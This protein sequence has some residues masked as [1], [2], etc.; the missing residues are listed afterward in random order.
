MASTGR[1]GE[2][3]QTGLRLSG[4]NHFSGL[5]G[6]SCPQLSGPWPWGGEVR[7]IA[8]G[9]REPD[10]GGG[11]DMNLDWLVCIQKAPL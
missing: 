4:L 3:G 10:K 7:W 6:M 2:A 5:R 11:K 9:V 8:R 1:D